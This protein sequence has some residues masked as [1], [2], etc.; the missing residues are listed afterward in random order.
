V[1]GRLKHV[2]RKWARFRDKDMLKIKHLKQV[3]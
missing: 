1:G 2:S 3:A